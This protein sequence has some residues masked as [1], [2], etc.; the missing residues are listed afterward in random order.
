MTKDYIYIKFCSNDNIS[1]S[2]LKVKLINKCNK[3]VFCGKTDYFGRIKMPIR[4]NEVY[5][6]IIYSNLS[7]I[8]IPLIAKKNKLYCININNNNLNNGKHLITIILTDKY[9]PNIKIKGGKMI[10]WQDTQS[11]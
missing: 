2:N 9:N 6:L 3:I 5:I 4:D 8:K 7:I 11:Q 1:P 10:L